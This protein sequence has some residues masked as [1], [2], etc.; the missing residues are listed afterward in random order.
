[1]LLRGRTLKFQTNVRLPGINPSA[2]RSADKVMDRG[3]CSWL[4][5][6]KTCADPCRRAY[7]STSDLSRHQ[8]GR[9]SA[10]TMR[11][12]CN[13]MHALGYMSSTRALPS[14]EAVPIGAPG[15]TKALS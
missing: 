3:F 12:V 8:Q 1:M 5:Q 13:S 2:V 11:E 6:V 7:D 4:R 15:G 14:Q 10:S 9:T